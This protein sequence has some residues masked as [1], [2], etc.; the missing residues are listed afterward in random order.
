MSHEEKQEKYVCALRS[1]CLI[2]QYEA[3]GVVLLL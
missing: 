1:R 2:R 3:F